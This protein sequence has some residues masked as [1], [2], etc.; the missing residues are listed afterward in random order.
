MKHINIVFKIILPLLLGLF[1]IAV[2]SIYANFFLLQ[3]QISKKSNET[4]DSISILLDT[5]IQQDTDLMLGLIEQL[6]KDEKI[7]TLFKSKKREELYKYLEDTYK[8]Y[9]QRYDITHFYIHKVNKQN[10]LRVHNIKT[11]SDFINRVTLNNASK[12][13]QY[14][15]GIEF[16]ISHN[17]TLRVVMPW[18]VDGV[19]LGYIEL[20]KEVDKFTPRLTEFVNADIIFTIKKS[21]ISSENFDKWKSN[22]NRNRHYEIMD[23]FYVI[24]STISILEDELQKHLD[25]DENSYNQYIEN[26]NKKYFINT[27]PFLDIN[28]NEV[29]HINILID[30]S[31]DY[32]FLYELIF[33]V[34]SIV[35]I[36]ILCLVIYYYK[37]LQK[38]EDELKSVYLQM[39]KVSISDA[40]TELYNKRYYLNN[41]PKQIKKA[42]RYNRYI[43]FVLIDIDN[44]KKYN[45]NYGHLLGDKVLHD[46]AGVLKDVFKRSTD[47][48]YRVGGEEFLII[49]ESDDKENGLHMSELLLKAITKLQIDHFY[50]E[51]FNVI[52]VSIGVY[53]CE[54]TKDT[55]I[56]ELYDNADKALYRSKH[57]GR[58]QVT[59]F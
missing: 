46:I 47:C 15:S 21:L 36:L 17:L 45:D 35:F 52:T 42:S 13:S 30:V 3:K 25:K 9:E 8:S 40:L 27:R 16:G 54:A 56:D 2:V 19:L 18:R 28:R 48:C 37:F 32:K 41:A 55:K 49:S 14:S 39:H 10:F 11:H 59:L 50:N 29:G 1:L 22:D 5:I 57:N 33:N 38:K 12:T 20:G 58:N 26:D 6:E 23:N 44:F 53:T 4:F 43:S 34:S 51:S 24:D 31:E 7:I